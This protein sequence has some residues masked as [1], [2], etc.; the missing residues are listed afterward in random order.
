VREKKW[1]EKMYIIILKVLIIIFYFTCAV[2][3]PLVIQNRTHFRNCSHLQMRR[4]RDQK[5]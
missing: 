5:T 4:T 3:S 1:G 2:P